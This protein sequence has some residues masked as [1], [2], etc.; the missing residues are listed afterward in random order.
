MNTI[1][2]KMRKNG[3]PMKIKGN[4]GKDDELCYMIN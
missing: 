4:G 3:Y 2:G 1:V